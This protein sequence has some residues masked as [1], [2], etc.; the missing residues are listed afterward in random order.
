MALPA[1][2]VEC[3]SELTPVP[4]SLPVWKQ[5]MGAM[6]SAAADVKS[7]EQHFLTLQVLFELKTELQIIL[8]VGNK[9]DN[10]VMTIFSDLLS[11]FSSGCL[12]KD[13]DEQGPGCRWEGCIT[14]SAAD[15]TQ[16]HAARTA[17]CR[18]SR[19]P[20]PHRGSPL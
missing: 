17:L 11:V 19:A 5:E 2:Q 9:R 8:F 1:V 12:K 3:Y 18:L 20:L 10:M 4:I 6:L 16:G 14:R 13:Q 7:R 15:L